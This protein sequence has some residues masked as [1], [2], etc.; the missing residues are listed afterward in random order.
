MV[1]VAATYLLSQSLLLP[2]G[3]ALRSLLP[4]GRIP[5][6][7]QID[8][9]IFRSLTKSVIVRSP[10]T[11]N[12]SDLADDSDF[13]EF[14]EDGE[15]FDD[16]NTDDNVE[17]MENAEDNSIDLVTNR[18]SHNGSET[19]NLEDLI[20]TFVSDFVENGE[21]SSA[22]ELA[23]EAKH[24]LQLEQPVKS[25]LIVLTSNASIN[26]GSHKPRKSGDVKTTSPMV[27][28]STNITYVKPMASKASLS[29]SSVV[30]QNDHATTINISAMVD[31]IGEKRNRY[32]MPP[33]KVTSINEMN[34]ILLQHRQSSRSMV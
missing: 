24:G 32:E 31:T 14:V 33:E 30:L 34:G 27:T 5:V 11:V 15:N 13:N 25:N 17:Q 26:D 28:P 22:V 21:N 6:H 7:D 20:D 18:E 1:V 19:E 29:V 8:H 23:T 16:G 12:V 3:N 10:L 9:P 4:D 2:Y